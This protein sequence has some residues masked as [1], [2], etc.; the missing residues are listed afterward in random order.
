MTQ[1]RD[2]PPVGDVGPPG[3]A[4]GQIAQ[5]LSIKPDTQN[6]SVVAGSQRRQVIGRTGDRLPRG[7]VKAGHTAVQS[8]QPGQAVGIGNQAFRRRD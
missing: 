5:D 2:H 8:L 1:R 7:A 6:C 3:I 4:L